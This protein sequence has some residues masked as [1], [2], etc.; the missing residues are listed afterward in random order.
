MSRKK[1]KIKQSSWERSKMHRLGGGCR[2]RGYRI[3]KDG[4]QEVSED[5]ACSAQPALQIHCPVTLSLV[6]RLG[7]ALKSQPCTATSLLPPELSAFISF[8]Y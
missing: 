7:V 6:P 1:T 4:L 2:G 3:G 8:Y 5:L